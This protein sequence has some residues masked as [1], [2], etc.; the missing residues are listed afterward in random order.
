MCG[1]IHL[2][3]VHEDFGRGIAKNT[4]VEDDGLVGDGGPLL[5]YVTVAIVVGR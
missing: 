1:A 5:H 3:V 4:K 2:E